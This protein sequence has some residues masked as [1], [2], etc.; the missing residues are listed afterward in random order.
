MRTTIAEG[1]LS[2][3]CAMKGYI[4]LFLSGI[5][6]IMLMYIRKIAEEVIE[7]I[8]SLTVHI[9]IHELSNIVVTDIFTVKIFMSM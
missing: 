8:R 4:N 6:C 5:S 1:F 7:Y 3:C 2:S 9:L